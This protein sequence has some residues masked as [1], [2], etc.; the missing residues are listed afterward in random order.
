M[1]LWDLE[2]LGVIAAA[3]FTLNIVCVAIVTSAVALAR[4]W[5]AEPRRSTSSPHRGTESDV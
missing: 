4:R 2:A 5:S 3:A 1:R